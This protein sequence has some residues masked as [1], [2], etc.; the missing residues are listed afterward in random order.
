MMSDT[1]YRVSGRF[2]LENC[3]CVRACVCQPQGPRLVVEQFQHAEA[4][5][6]PFKAFDPTTVTHTYTLNATSLGPLGTTDPAALQAFFHSL[7]NM[8]FHVQVRVCA[9][10]WR[11][12]CLLGRPLLLLRVHVAF[13]CDAS[14]SPLQCFR[15]HVLVRGCGWGAF[16]H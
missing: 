6:D 4:L 13:C 1:V 5:V 2:A 11:A 10:L 14:I 9:R 16:I 8:D 12:L 7:V 15:N 3:S